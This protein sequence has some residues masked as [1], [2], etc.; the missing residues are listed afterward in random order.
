MALSRI[1]LANKKAR[2]EAH[3]RQRQA[4]S[5]LVQEKQRVRQKRTRKMLIEGQREH[6]RAKHAAIA[7]VN[8]LESELAD[9]V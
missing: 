2:H 7:Y 5:K 8:E 1:R 6:Q 9:E 4:K 3:R